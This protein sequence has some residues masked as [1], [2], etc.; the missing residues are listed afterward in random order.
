LGIMLA[1]ADRMDKQF[2]SNQSSE[3]RQSGDTII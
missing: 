3:Q 2:Q 1:P